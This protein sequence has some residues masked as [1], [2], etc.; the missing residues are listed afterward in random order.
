MEEELNQ[1]MHE[2]Q[3]NESNAKMN[4]EQRVKESKQK[5]IDENIKKAEKSGNVLTQTIDEEGNLIGVNNMNSND[6]SLSSENKGTE[7]ISVADIR[8]ELFEGDNIVVGK[9]DYGQSQ[10]VSGP[11]ATNNKTIEE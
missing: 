11:F 10:L 7:E 6:F 1:L 2:K 4:F 3:K 5:A 9:T 8:T